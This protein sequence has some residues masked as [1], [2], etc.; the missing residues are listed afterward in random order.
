MTFYTIYVS[1]LCYLIPTKNMIMEEIVRKIIKWRGLYSSEERRLLVFVVGMVP[2]IPTA[3]G[4]DIVEIGV[5]V[6]NS[7]VLPHCS[8]HI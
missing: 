3:V 7:G 8:T 5:G 6:D 2:I 4:N 1:R